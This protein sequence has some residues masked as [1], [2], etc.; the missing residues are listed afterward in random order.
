MRIPDHLPQCR[1]PAIIG[2][3]CTEE[4]HIYSARDGFISEEVAIRRSVGVDDAWTRDIES[5]GALPVIIP[6]RGVTAEQVLQERFLE[7]IGYRVEMLSHR[8]R[9]ERIV[10]FAAV[11][12]KDITVRV[13]P[14]SVRSRIEL[15]VEGA[16][17]LSLPDELL[18]RYRLEQ[19][20][21][22][23]IEHALRPAWQHKGEP[24][25]AAQ[26]EP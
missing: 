1:Q 12:M 15:V 7:E 3:V 22:R 6:A 10:L 19:A 4:A 16:Y 18:Q 25:E 9:V 26:R 14:P 2:V 20:R 5:R 17:C 23:R 24:L 11:S 21:R 13:L 8:K